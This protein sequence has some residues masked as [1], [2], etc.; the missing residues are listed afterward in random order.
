MPRG[1]GGDGDDD[2]AAASSHFPVA[3]EHASGSAPLGTLRALARDGTRVRA[4]GVTD[5]I[6]HGVAAFE[7]ALEIEHVRALR[8]MYEI[9]SLMRHPQWTGDG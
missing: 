9:D 8:T 1:R 2:E 7:R 3:F 5:M 6:L 4:A